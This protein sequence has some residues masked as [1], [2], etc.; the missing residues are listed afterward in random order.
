MDTQ[1]GGELSCERCHDAEL[2]E[3]G[4]SENTKTYPPRTGGSHSVD[5]AAEL[6]LRATTVDTEMYTYSGSLV[7]I[8]VNAGTAVCNN[9]VW[10]HPKTAP[11]GI[12]NYGS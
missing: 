7:K 6:R 12:N 3:D 1:E 2:V 11:N 5:A 4:M 10:K 8:Q 9:S